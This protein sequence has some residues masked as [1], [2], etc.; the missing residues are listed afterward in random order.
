MATITLEV[1]DELAE[2]L[3]GVDDLPSVLAYAIDL[4]GLPRKSVAPGSSPHWNEVLD[5]LSA[6][7]G[8]DEILDFKISDSAQD[9]LEELLHLSRER[10]LTPHERDEM[11]AFL[12]IDHL[13][14][15][16]KARLREAKP[17]G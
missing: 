15:M 3:E 16:L 13:F 10:E 4:A 6:S 1:P 12:A 5:F 11:D 7:P 14:V 9:R 8:S 17:S 2:Q